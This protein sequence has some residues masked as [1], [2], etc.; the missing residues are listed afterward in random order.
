ML[1]FCLAV[2]SQSQSILSEYPEFILEE[3]EQYVR[4]Q[5]Y[6]Q[7]TINVQ[8]TGEVLEVLEFDEEGHL[9]QIDPNGQGVIMTSSFGGVQMTESF[10]DEL[11]T[12]F[13]YNETGD[14]ISKVVR[15]EIDGRLTIDSLRNNYQGGRLVSSKRYFISDNPHVY[16][17]KDRVGITEYEYANDRMI[18]EIKYDRLT[19]R[20]TVQLLNSEEIIYDWI[21]NS[22]CRLTHH[23]LETNSLGT[24]YVEKKYFDVRGRLILWHEG[25]VFDEDEWWTRCSYESERAMVFESHMK[26]RIPKYIRE[27]LKYNHQGKLRHIKM[28][29][30]SKL[31]FDY[32]R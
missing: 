23:Y 8:K 27:E 6:S 12:S 18:K 15:T 9:A 24:N 16:M 28:S 20:D 2:E 17:I 19:I 13:D 4:E 22:E 11:G 14:L 7:V 29:D 26:T 1:F 31:I 25:E 32:K 21:G 30:G 5:G 3:L 10:L